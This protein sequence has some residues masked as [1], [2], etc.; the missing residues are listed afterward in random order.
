[1]KEISV[2]DVIG[3]NMIGPS[4]SHT[5]GA[6]KIALVTKKLVG[7]DIAS[8]EFILYGSFAQTYKGHGTDRALI[9]GML[10][11]NTEDIRIKDAINLAQDAKLKYKFTLAGTSDHHPNVVDILV[12]HNNGHKTSVM[13]ASIGGGNIKIVNIN[14]V[15]IEFTGEYYTLLIK[16]KDI[17]GVV[18]HITN[19]LSGC[20][21]NIAF[22]RLYREEKGELAYTIIEADN[23]MDD[24]VIRFIKKNKSILDV[25]AIESI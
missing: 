15:D 9:A 6:L 10:G 21:I 25:N 3:P 5:A 12:T 20:D 13:G 18:A 22:M 16:Q 24:E 2:F 4:S 11:M 23:P 1:M 14:G 17:K 19:C 7:D 8:V